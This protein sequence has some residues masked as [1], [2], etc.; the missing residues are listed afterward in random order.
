M[1]SLR[2]TGDLLSQIAFYPVLRR[3]SLEGLARPH[4]GPTASTSTRPLSHSSRRWPVRGYELAPLRG[5]CA[6]KRWSRNASTWA[7]GNDS[8]AFPAQTVDAAAIASASFMGP[9]PGSPRCI[10]SWSNAGCGL[11]F[12]ASC[13]PSPPARAQ[14]PRSWPLHSDGRR[15]RRAPDTRSGRPGDRPRRVRSARSRST[16]APRP[17]M[18][19]RRFASSVPRHG[20]PLPEP[21]EQQREA[22]RASPRRSARS[23]AVLRRPQEPKQRQPGHPP[24]PL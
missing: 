9:P 8:A 18:R 6:P 24:L 5:A 10:P 22:R 17:R 2:F 4:A 3:T 7:R 14:R 23:R 19:R 15:R 21:S 12:H 16:P 1:S 11:C 20:Q 13:S